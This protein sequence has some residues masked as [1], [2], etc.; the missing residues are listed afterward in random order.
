MI[1]GAVV[2]NEDRVV[3]LSEGTQFVRLDTL[4]H[5]QKRLPNPAAGRGREGR[6]QAVA[7]MAEEG[8]EKFCTVPGCFCAA[9][10]QAAQQA[11]IHFLLMP[12]GITF[13]QIV[14]TVEYFPFEEV[15]ALDAED[16]CSE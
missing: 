5:T 4:A 16:L 9:S 15:D 3:A 12:E 1:I 8:I 2:D 6:L 13:D 11:G 14:R 10:H 7:Q